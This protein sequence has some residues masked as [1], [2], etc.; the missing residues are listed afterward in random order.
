M[1]Y[2]RTFLYAWTGKLE[3]AKQVF[4]VADIL[5]RAF[6]GGY[7]LRCTPC[8]T[9]GSELMPCARPPRWQPDDQSN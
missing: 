9:C 4:D 7:K 1:G 5:S 8:P 3:H 6:D 2:E